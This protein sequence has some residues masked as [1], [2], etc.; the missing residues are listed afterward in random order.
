MTACVALK[1][2]AR[3]GGFE[4]SGAG[5][6]RCDRPRAPQITSDTTVTY[7][8]P[9]PLFDEGVTRVSAQPSGSG[10]FEGSSR[11][12]LEIPRTPTYRARPMSQ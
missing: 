6:M 8:S 5:A 12:R 7:R 11:A 3:V 9:R 10:S 4:F 2:P 1:P